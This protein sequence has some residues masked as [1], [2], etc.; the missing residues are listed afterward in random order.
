M[1]TRKDRQT[2]SKNIQDGEDEW[3]DRCT[4]RQ[5][6]RQTDRWTEK[7]RQLKTSEYK[8]RQTDKQ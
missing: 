1:K 2:N 5:T 7:S 8:K 6:D 3:T 4:D